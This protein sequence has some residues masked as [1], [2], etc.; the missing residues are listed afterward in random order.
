M[1]E[2]Q[3]SELKYKWENQVL[4]E[5]SIK[6]GIIDCVR[7]IHDILRNPSNYGFLGETRIDR[8]FINELSYS[9]RVLF[10]AVTAWIYL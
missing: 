2:Q 7:T 10:N 4:R 6:F 1:N 5:W 3:L 8:K 9:D